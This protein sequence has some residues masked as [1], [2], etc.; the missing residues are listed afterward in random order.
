MADHPADLGLADWRQGDVALGVTWFVQ[1][2]PPEEAGETHAIIEDGVKGLV[3]VTQTCDIVRPAEHRPYIEF[4]PLVEMASPEAFADVERGARPAYAV[5]PALRG[6]RL[7]ADLDRSM[8]VHKAVVSGWPRTPGWSTDPEIRA[9]AQALARKRARFAFPDDFVAVVSSLQ[10]RVKRK[11]GRVSEEGEALR[12]LREIRVQA[13]PEWDAAA[14]DVM[15][16][17]IRERGAVAPAPRGWD[18]WLGEW[19]GLLRPAG[20]FQAVDGTVVGLDA[21]TAEEYVAS[22]PLDL[23]YLSGP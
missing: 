12:A 3:A 17:F 4:A 18:G 8:T 20:R 13:T 14:V 5:V 7:V 6:R 22:D 1:V 9:F 16:Y 21:L 10:D 15:I 19:L 11:H 2:E 23:D